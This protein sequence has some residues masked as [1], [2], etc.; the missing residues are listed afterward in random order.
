MPERRV[1]HLPLP[2]TTFVKGRS[3]RPLPGWSDVAVD[4]DTRFAW[5]CDLFD[6]GCYFEAH[7]LWEACWLAARDDNCTDDDDTRF[8]HGLIRLAAA[9]VKL[10]DDKPASRLAH[11]EGAVAYLRGLDGARRGI[12]ASTVQT[13]VDEL[14]A[15]R[16]PRLS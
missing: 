16:R 9:G 7:E 12:D 5:G 14:R 15:G 2:S 11:V 8:L 13:A 10:L 1:P 3:E 6:A 4:D